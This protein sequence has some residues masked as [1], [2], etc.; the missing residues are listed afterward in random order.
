MPT[1]RVD[2]DDFLS[3]KRIAMVGVSRNPQDFSR[4]L[5]RDLI[6]RGYDVVPVN[7]LAQE[8]EDKKAYTTVQSIW[9]PVEAALLMTSPDQTDQ[10]VHDCLAAGVRRV[11]MHRGGGQ[12]AVSPKAVAFCKENGI[13]VVEGHCPFMFLPDTPLFHRVHGFLLKLGGRYPRGPVVTQHA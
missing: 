8:I 4:A 2:I 9:P 6:R 13:R 10:V 5:F 12:G 7:P 11:W 1:T 3:C